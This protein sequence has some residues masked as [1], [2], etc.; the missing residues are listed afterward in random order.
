ME[1]PLTPLV[2][3]ILAVCGGKPQAD[4]PT[5]PGGSDTWQQQS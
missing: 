5:N 2:Q 1:T 4:K 3:L